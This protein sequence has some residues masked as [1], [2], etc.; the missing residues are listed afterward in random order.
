MVLMGRQGSGGCCLC[1]VVYN[2]EDGHSWC[3]MLKMVVWSRAARVEK[4]HVLVRHER[5]LEHTISF[6]GVRCLMG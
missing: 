6:V 2:V 3:V 4:R 5:W 1:C